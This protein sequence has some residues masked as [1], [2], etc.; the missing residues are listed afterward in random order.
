MPKSTHL[1]S[2]TGLRFAAALAV[3]GFHIGVQGLFAHSQAGHLLNL[4]F[5]HGAT[6]VNFFF[7]LSGFV[8]TWSARPDDTAG[9]IWRRRLAKIMPN[10]IATWLIAFIGVIYVGTNAVSFP[11]AIPS[12]FLVQAWVPIE[13]VFFGVNTP[14]WS[15][16]CEAAFYVAFPLLLAAIRKARANL[17][18]L[19]AGGLVVLIALVPVIAL[20]LPRTI[21]YWLVYIC[22]AT[23]GLEFVLGMVVARIVQSGRRIRVGLW[24]AS[25]CII[26]CYVVMSYYPPAGFSTVIITVVPIALLIYAAAVADITHRTSPWRSR[27]LVWLG[28]ISFAFYLVHQI[29]IRSIYK[30]MSSPTMSALHELALVATILTVALV[31]GWLLYR[32]VERPMM[33]I[34]TQRRSGVA[35][36]TTAIAG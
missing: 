27:I 2:L 4:L 34:L 22:P 21:A 31:A 24:S 9:G 8:L 16:S 35:Q 1:P 30:V 7:V 12:L 19:L 25:G 36:S 15:L 17:L 29:V 3:F 5:K 6:G 32:I 23:R 14:A 11:S 13:Q 20:P 26:A 33:R 18:W 10:H 28:E